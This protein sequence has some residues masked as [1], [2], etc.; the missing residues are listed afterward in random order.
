MVDATPRLKGSGIGHPLR[1]HQKKRG[2]WILVGLAVLAAALTFGLER[3]G[4]LERAEGWSYDRRLRLLAP[5]R[6]SEPEK[7]PVAVVAVDEESLRRYGQWPLP[8]HLYGQLL[9]IL[10]KAGVRAVGFD[11]LLA[12]PDRHGPE[13]D[14]AL[15]RAIGDGPPVVLGLAGAAKVRRA[16]EPVLTLLPPFSEPL[17]RFA[18]SG[19]SVGHLLA[20]PDVDGVVRRLPLEVEVA[21]RGRVPAF[22]LALARLAGGS[23]AV[24]SVIAGARAELLLDFRKG[25][26]PVYSL[27]EVLEGSVSPAAL[28]G[29]AVVVGV[30]ASGLP[31]RY[32]T[33]L[34]PAGDPVPGVELQALAVATLLS[35]G[36]Q[37]L[38][39][40][41]LSGSTLLAALLGV[42]AGR[43]GWGAVP[44]GLAGLLLL[45]GSGVVA[46]AAGYWLPVAA[47]AT[48]L[49]GALLASLGWGLS[50]ER[51]EQAR[52]AALFGRY[53]SPEVCRELLRRPDRPSLAGE[54]VHLT[55]LFADLRGF[56]AFSAGCAPEEAVD[57]LNRYLGIMV[58]A[59]QRQ[60]G[61]VDK[62]LGDGIMAFFG[63][64]LP[65]ANPGRAALAA[66]REMMT[67]TAALGR[68]LAAAGRP[69][70]PL[71]VGLASGE[72]LVG[73]IGTDT[74]SDYTAIGN[75]VNLAS[76][77]EDLARPGEIL[78][79][80]ETWTAAGEE[81]PA[82][83]RVEE[84][85][86][87]GWPVP[88]TVVRLSCDGHHCAAQP[89]Q[90]E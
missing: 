66:A 48:G 12:E 13:S 62:F 34:T 89:W 70:L 90:L 50:V 83:S 4:L 20:V 59:V 60:R 65:S 28:R 43:T 68:E 88:V 16:G 73:S 78:V 23:A 31:D 33:P 39:L 85:E 42:L 5:A 41:W 57:T 79:D 14:D 56:T 1:R 22:C 26:I 72:A 47:P 64:P 54:R 2:G 53:L 84:M 27:A 29:R 55:V 35:G 51:R 30:T 81:V 61:T 21:G 75:P 11:L 46:L 87:E 6:G 63:A 40:S 19:A 67:R 25:G 77:L 10:R 36:V 38:P 76:R 82:G 74:R 3:A 69:A 44:L 58:E 8:R 15:A 32:H 37:A 45:A 86:V 52:L 9:E 24:P 49:F 18:E 7:S 71:G 17:P 80:Q